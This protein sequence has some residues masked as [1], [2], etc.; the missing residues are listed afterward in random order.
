MELVYIKM[1]IIM[2]EIF[3]VIKVNLNFIKI[4][5]LSIVKEKLIGMIVK[6]MV[7]V[8]NIDVIIK[9]KNLEIEILNMIWKELLVII[10]DYL[11]L[12]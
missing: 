4:E 6:N 8:I 2:S 3:F 7:V 10:G 5:I 12:I 9:S 1:I 11:I